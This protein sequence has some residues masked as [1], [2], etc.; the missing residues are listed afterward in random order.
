M[1]S[2]CLIALQRMH[3]RWH[4]RDIL[5]T[6][7]SMAVTKS[8]RMMMVA[9][10]PIQSLACTC[11]WTLAASQL[12]CVIGICLNGNDRNLEQWVFWALLSPRVQPWE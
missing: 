4:C 3:F 7:R 8:G 2:N 1:V 5:V 11:G 10:M 6:R 12:A 9:S